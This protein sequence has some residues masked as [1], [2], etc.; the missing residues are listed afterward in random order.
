MAAWRKRYTV[1]PEEDMCY[2]L[3]R[4]NEIFMHKV[5]ERHLAP[6]AGIFKIVKK[7]FPQCYHCWQALVES[8]ISIASPDKVRVRP[9]PGFLYVKNLHMQMRRGTKRPRVFELYL[10]VPHSRSRDQRALIIYAVV[11]PKAKLHWPP[12]ISNK[13]KIS[14]FLLFF[15]IVFFL[16]Y[17]TTYNVN[18]VNKLNWIE[19]NWIEL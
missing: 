1:V 7:K 6:P 2:S 15:V 3:L 17:I 16:S 18:I 8:D 12:H 11:S 5:Y 4:N 10:L 13:V 14:L 9:Y 19:L